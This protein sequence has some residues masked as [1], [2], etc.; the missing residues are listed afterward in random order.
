MR[1]ALRPAIF[2]FS[3]PEMLANSAKRPADAPPFY[4]AGNLI[5]AV[6]NPEPQQKKTKGEGQRERA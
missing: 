3:M 4:A 6:M 1:Q 2:P 5:G